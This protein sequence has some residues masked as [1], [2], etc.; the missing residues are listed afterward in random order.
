M[1][2]QFF[3]LFVFG[4]VAAVLSAICGYFI[5]RTMRCREI[6]DLLTQ[7]LRD[8]LPADYHWEPHTDDSGEST[9][10]YSHVVGP[11]GRVEG[12]RS[13]Q[14]F[15]VL[16]TSAGANIEIL[17]V[18]SAIRS[19]V[20]AWRQVAACRT[21][22][23]E[24]AAP[25]IRESKNHP[26]TRLAAELLEAGK[27]FSGGSIPD[28]ISRAQAWLDQ[29]FDRM[30]VCDWIRLNVWDPRVA[31]E[32]R[33][34]GFDPKRHAAKL[35]TG[36]TA[37]VLQEL[38][39]GT[40]AFDDVVWSSVD[41]KLDIPMDRLPTPEELQA[42]WRELEDGEQMAGPDNVVTNPDGSDI[43]W[44][45]KININFPY[46]KGT[47]KIHYTRKTKPSRFTEEPSHANGTG[48]SATV[49]AES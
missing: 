25:L 24:I 34:R 6:C 26:R 20:A 28:A 47:H 11:A 27:V 19:C 22:P 13:E 3:R 10:T 23:M 2:E 39:R 32:L 15:H 7:Y 38:C 43:H 44:G 18:A 12:M 33:T 42:N 46:R 35:A 30:Q 17:L 1:F 16:C 21:A 36:H 31:A 45:H 14:S 9:R 40:V 4:F 48:P 8:K 49:P 41:A 29:R 5:G 37:D